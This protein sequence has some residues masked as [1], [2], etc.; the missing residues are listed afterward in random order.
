MRHIVVTKFGNKPEIFGNDLRYGMIGD[1][2]VTKLIKV[3]AS[4]KDNFV[5][6]YGK[7]KWDYDK[8][9]EYFGDNVQFVECFYYDTKLTV[10][11]LR[12]DEFHVLLGP[13][14][15]YNGGL[16]IPAWE[17]I[18]T[19]M[20]PERLLE[21]VA[22]Q[23]KLMNA[24]PDALQFFY[25]T[26]RRF[27]LKA[28]D[29]LNFPDK[30]FAQ[31]LKSAIYEV[32]ALYDGDYTNTYIKHITV[33]PFRFDS[34]WLFEKDYNKYK[35][36][37][38]KDKHTFFVIPANQ[39]T[40]D[41][42]I[43]HSR[44]RKILKYISGDTVDTIDNFTICGKWTH[45]DTKQMFEYLSDVPQYLDGLALKEYNALLEDSK[46]ALITFNTDDG[47]KMFD[48]NYLTPKY[49][50]CVYS[51]CLTF[52]EKQYNSI[53]F[54]P[55][56]L[57]VGNGKELKDKLDLCE[58]DDKYKNMLLELQDTLVKREYFS[59]QYFMELFNKE[60]FS[61]GRN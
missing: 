29:L 54:I 2:E 15:Y 61:N 55:E 40:S 25:M 34:I 31:N 22:P 21:R 49:W 35:E 37:L 59:G 12:P 39:V 47:P 32:Q 44:R 1:W 23:I 27:L 53:P 13:H 41:K 3:L 18:K 7:A 8:A 20:V 9:K 28:A 36:N 38:K 42:E 24:C 6:Y 10:E 57:Q 17:S 60:R 43:E 56:E 46:Y 45:E 16:N 11:Q 4:D 30:I 26:D 33:E 50:E 14:A 58:K 48:N 19:S 52:V 51:G 5:T